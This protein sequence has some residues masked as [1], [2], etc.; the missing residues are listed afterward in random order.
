MIQQ[1]VITKIE[2][3]IITAELSC[4]EA[5]GSCKAKALCGTEQK[6]EIVLHLDN[7]HRRVGDIVS[8]EVART[9]GL[10]AVGLVYLVPVALMLGILITG[11]QL[12]WLPWITGLGA[13]GGAGLYFL[14]VKLAGVGK[15]IEITIID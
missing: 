8:I 15:G 5:C 7:D 2:G 10:R 14:I 13:L 4:S 12:G 11:E 1:A 9:A 3:E 6:K